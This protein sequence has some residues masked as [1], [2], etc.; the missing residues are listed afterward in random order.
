MPT[1]AT[2]NT[3]GTGCRVGKLNV[4]YAE[5]VEHGSTM[6]VVVSVRGG[7]PVEKACCRHFDLGFSREVR[8]RELLSLSEGRFNDLEVI[9][10]AQKIPD[11][12]VG[13]RLGP[14]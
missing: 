11:A 14:G 13:V 5:I 8:V 9:D 3:H 6:E 7:G 4:V 1:A 12:L 10:I 2:D